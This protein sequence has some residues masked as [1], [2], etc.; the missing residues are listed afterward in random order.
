MR[1]LFTNTL[2]YVTA[3]FWPLPF[4]YKRPELTFLWQQGY[5]GVLLNIM[6]APHIL[7]YVIEQLRTATF[8]VASEISTDIDWFYYLCLEGGKKEK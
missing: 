4:I 1:K 8:V 2:H 5:S 6:I 3:Q 7:K